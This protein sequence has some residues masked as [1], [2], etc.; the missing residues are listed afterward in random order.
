MSLKEMN[1]QNPASA[2]AWVLHALAEEIEKYNCYGV[3]IG[4]TRLSFVG[5]EYE[6]MDWDGNKTRFCDLSDA[7]V[8]F[9]NVQTA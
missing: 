4:L 3:R 6:V 8:K 7:I 2:Y 5:N 1:N 9:I